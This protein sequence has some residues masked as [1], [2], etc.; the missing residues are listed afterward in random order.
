MGSSAPPPAGGNGDSFIPIVSAD[1]QQVLFASMADNLVI[2]TNSTPLAAS[3]P[4]KLNVFLRD[5]TNASTMLVSK[6]LV[7]VSGNGDS[8]PMG[9]STNNRYVLFESSASDLVS[10]D[11]NNASDI[12]VRDLTAGST[13]LVSVNTN[14]QAGNN[15]SRNACFTP[16][17][18]Y[19]AFVSAATDLVENDTNDIPDIFVR[20]LQTGA[21]VLVSSGAMAVNGAS[22][23]E[24]PEISDDGRFVAFW[25]TATN[26]VPGVETSGEIYVRDIIE[27][28]TIWASSA[29]GGLLESL[30]QATN[31]ICFNH[32]LS[33]DG[34]FVGFQI[35]S[36]LSSRG[37]VLRYDRESQ[38]TDLIH[39]NA[40]A[41]G[42]PYEEVR[43]LEMTP[44]G[45][46]IV[47]IANT[48][49]VSPT[50][51]SV[52]VWSADTGT[53]TI[54]S[55][56]LSN[57]TAIG[58]WPSIDPTGRFVLF[59]SNPHLYLHDLQN[60][61]TTL[62]NADTNGVGSD[63]A[64]G[65]IPSSSTNGGFI[66]FQAYD[67]ALVEND[68][69]RKYDVFLRDLIAGTT[70]MIS[71]R[72]PASASSSPNGSSTVFSVSETGR[73]VA[74][75]SEANNLVSND[76]NGVRDVFVRDLSNGTN[77]L[78]SF[79]TN[80]VSA[81][82]VSSDPTISSDGRYV[83]FTSSASNLLPIGA[84]SINDVYVFDVQTGT[85]S[86]GTISTTGTASGNNE[87]AA[88]SISDEGRYLLFRSKASN[89]APGS[90]TTGTENLFVRDRQSL[91]TV[92]LTTAGMTE[93]MMT[94]NGRHVAFIGRLPGVSSTNLYIW[95]NVLQTRVF[96]NTT[97]GIRGISISQDGNKVAFVSGTNLFVADRVADTIF[98][99]GSLG[100][101]A[102]VDLQFSGDG[103][104]LTYASSYPQGFN[105]QNDANDVYLYD[106]TSHTTTLVSHARN[107]VEAA[108]GASDRPSISH[109]GR[110]IV[111][112]SYASNIIPNDSNGFPDL[113]IYDR[114]NQTT[115]LLTAGSSNQSNN[116][117]FAAKFSGDGRSLIFPS[118]ASNLNSGDGNHHGNLFVFAFLYLNISSNTDSQGTT[119]SWPAIPA[120][121]F[122]IQYKDHLNQQNW[123][124]LTGTISFEEGTASIQD[125]SPESASRF[126]RLLAN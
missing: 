111:Y 114:P 45:R 119:I 66:A 67:G 70:E 71:E 84:N 77:I 78:A 87:S 113:F 120:Q 10:N 41:Y 14:G 11:T 52:L 32:A 62:V 103:Q 1:G 123:V 36:N 9:I 126:Y 118:W 34:R 6:N 86:L 56:E 39:T 15:L 30:H 91:T 101:N 48:N 88:L 25:S 33:G 42:A 44:D 105:D 35:S 110:F 58:E 85:L 75:V 22:S 8:V 5:R 49:A 29:A 72:H 50:N 74:F 21:T 69:N 31:G 81:N 112:R 43:T 82:G 13:V 76:T 12:L 80:G 90:F 125:P 60:N 57:T 115:T 121:T 4:F 2:D 116:F 99:V 27:G 96:T 122:Q 65:A 47:F 108:D 19:V 20:D 63:I 73:Y 38:L 55:G 37:L 46:T 53:T 54:A 7:G 98:P 109:D 26:L 107:T 68:N 40:F 17:G 23:S 97:A 3:Y 95:D 93:A 94:A 59:V 64:I 117:S 106:F 28:T 79:S 18:R 92:A 61:V 24:A 100:L 16:D 83:A 51:T 124:N 102:R 89:L 104:F